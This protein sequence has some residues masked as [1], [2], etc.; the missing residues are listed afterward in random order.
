[1]C[2]MDI[3]VNVRYQ[4]TDR[5]TDRPNTEHDRPLSQFTASDMAHTHT[6]THTRTI[7]RHRAVLIGS[8]TTERRGLIMLCCV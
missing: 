2:E 7:S 8:Y 5:P 3:I 4:R 6:H 1:M